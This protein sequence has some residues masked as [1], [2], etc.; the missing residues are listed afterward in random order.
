MKLGQRVSNL[1][2]ISELCPEAKTR[3]QQYT[4]ETLYSKSYVFI[5]GRF[6][7]LP[8]DF[9]YLQWSLSLNIQIK[10]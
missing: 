5:E 3:A 2:I 1:K 7:L 4:P 8:N 10:T 9:I 6:G